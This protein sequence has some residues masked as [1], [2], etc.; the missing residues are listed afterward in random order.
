MKKILRP[1]LTPIVIFCFVLSICLIM[2]VK[3]SVAEETALR[4]VFVNTLFGLATGTVIAAA[5]TVADNDAHGDD[6]ARNLGIGATIGAFVGAS[7]GMAVET[8]SLVKVDG[9]RLN[10]HLPSPRLYKPSG[11]NESPAV[12]FNLLDWSY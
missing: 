6:W 7:Y 12:I 10:F 8:R 5:V 3:Q 1:Y 2:P 9:G 4:R 11:S